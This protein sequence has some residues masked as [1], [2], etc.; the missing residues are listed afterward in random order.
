MLAD[1]FEK[2]LGIDSSQ[3]MVDQ[4]NKKAA[5]RG[6]A[7]NVSATHIFLSSA[8]QIPKQDIIFSNLAFHHVDNL[9][10]M[11][12]LLGQCLNPGGHLVIVDFEKNDHSV[13][14]HPPGN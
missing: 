2:V 9:T 8:D 11:C 5:D 10:E 1:Q 3:G 7:Q 13:L 4:F 14:F 6:I 12:R